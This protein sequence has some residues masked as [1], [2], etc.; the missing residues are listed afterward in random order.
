MAIVKDKPIFADV[1]EWPDAQAPV[2][3]R[4]H[5]KP[6]L[7]EL[8]P[9]EF[10]EAL[11]ADKPDF[12]AVLDRY[13]GAEGGEGA[14]HRAVATNDDELGLCAQVVKNLRVAEQHVEAVHKVAKQ[15]Y[16]DGGRLVDA[17]KNSL[18]TRIRDGKSLV[19]GIMDAYAAKKLAAEREEARKR[20]EERRR[21]EELAR[22]NNLEQ[23]LP[24]AEPAPVRTGPIRSDSGATVSLG[25]EWNSVVED[26]PKAFKAVKQDA[27][28]KEAIDAAIKRLVKTTKGAPIAGV[29]I[30]E[31]VKTQAR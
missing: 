22:A 31:S 7:E 24:P 14:V 12:L 3:D 17:E 10:R 6:P 11:L 13:L 9:V 1:P 16:L 26:Y 23:A 25:T 4:H 20:D 15:P 5:N 27:K 30:W 28:V 29:R 8:I 19:Q 21:L 2:V 18:M